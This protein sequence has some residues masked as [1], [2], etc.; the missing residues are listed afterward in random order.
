MSAFK[1]LIADDEPYISR[2]LR[3]VLQQAGYEVT[4]VNN[5]MEALDAYAKHRPDVVVTDVRMPQMDGKK[6]VQSIRDM[7]IDKNNIPIIV[8]TSTLESENRDWV[9]SV[10]NVTF[11]GKPVSP[12]DLVRVVGNHLASNS[13]A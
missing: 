4:C 7:D 11:M 12:R 9:G 2:V 10:E 3:M 1:V 8:M 13:L 5:G 6:L